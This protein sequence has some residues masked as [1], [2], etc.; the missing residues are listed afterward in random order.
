MN[1]I[2]RLVLEST[3]LT[4]QIRNSYPIYKHIF[5][6]VKLLFMNELEITYFGIYLDRFSWL[7]QGFSFEEHLLIIALVAKVNIYLNKV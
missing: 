3:S 6:V 4:D 1:F 5:N 2:G 7:S